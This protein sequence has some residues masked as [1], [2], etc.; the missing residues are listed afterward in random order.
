MQ[1]SRSVS[2]LSHLLII[3]QMQREAAYDFARQLN[4]LHKYATALESSF[5]RCTGSFGKTNGGCV[6]AKSQHATFNSLWQQKVY[7]LFLLVLSVSFC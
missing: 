1:V 3:L 2:Y 5:T 7:V 4:T 6:F